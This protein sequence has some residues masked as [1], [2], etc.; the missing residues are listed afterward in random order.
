[1]PRKR[2][3]EGKKWSGYARNLELP[4]TGIFPAVCGGKEV[5]GYA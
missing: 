2:Q 4:M 1:M 5:E 3:T